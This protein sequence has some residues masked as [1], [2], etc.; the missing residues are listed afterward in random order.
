MWEQM[1]IHIEIEEQ[2]SI[3]VHDL[4][5]QVSDWNCLLQIVVQCTL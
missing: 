2:K 5:G 1:F 4:F 3:H